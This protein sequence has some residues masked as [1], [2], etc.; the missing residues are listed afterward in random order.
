MF[1]RP[2]VPKDQIITD[3]A[4]SV[5]RGSAYKIKFGL[6]ENPIIKLDACELKFALGRFDKITVMHNDEE[7][8]REFQETITRALNGDERYTPFKNEEI[9]VKI[10]LKLKEKVSAFQKSDLIDILVQFNDC[11]IMNGK[12]YSSFS[13]MDIKASDKVKPD[14]SF[15][16]YDIV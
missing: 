12:L 11:W 5:K 4:F 14:N 15:T 13:L 16:F 6:F 3:A 7:F 10:P 1:V 9:G 2:N 8:M